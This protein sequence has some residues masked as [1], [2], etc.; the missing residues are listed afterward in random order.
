MN[1]INE[2]NYC[3][4]F[5][6]PHPISM[7]CSNDIDSSNVDEISTAVES[8]QNVFSQ[9]DLDPFV[10]NFDN[11]DIKVEEVTSVD[12][13]VHN[14]IPNKN[15]ESE[16][17]FQEFE[18]NEIVIKA[19]DEI[20]P[21]KSF[22]DVLCNENGDSEQYVQIYE[23]NEVIV[24]SFRKPSSPIKLRSPQKFLC[25]ICGSVLGRRNSLTKHLR[26][27]H[28]NGRK[29]NRVT[30]QRVNVIPISELKDVYQLPEVNNISLSVN[31]DLQIITIDSPITSE[32]VVTTPDIS[33]SQPLLIEVIPDIM[34]NNVIT[35]HK[36]E[37]EK[38][39][40]CDECGK[41]FAN[42]YVLNTH[43][44]FHKNIRPFKCDYCPKSFKTKGQARTH[45]IR[46][47]TREKNEFV[48]RENESTTQ[49][50][51]VRCDFCGELFVNKY[52]LETHKKYHSGVRP[53]NC[54][55]CSKSFKTKSH[56]KVH[57]IRHSQNGLVA[58]SMLVKYMQN[59][60]NE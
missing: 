39:F 59:E 33:Y 44:Y 54:R 32:N 2:H 20:S 14:P 28:D 30:R 52:V 41:G 8:L 19:E 31:P 38:K 37:S 11:F 26:I 16:N 27:V 36:G 51:K 1:F 6:S 46:H 40:S 13:C 15:E 35:L 47:R 23:G 17:F 34:S 4:D 42:K 12:E 49:L 48:K 56:V 10:L 55:Y 7:F 43:K 3:K 58:K 45:Q 9:D 29:L 50:N 22:Q 60:S 57:E 18:G 25:D 5:G 24:E 53:Y 21:I